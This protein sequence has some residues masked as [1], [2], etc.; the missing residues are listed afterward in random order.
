MNYNPDMEGASVKD[1]FFAWFE[2]VEPTSRR[3]LR[4][5]KTHSFNLHL[6]VGKTTPLSWAICKGIGEG[7]FALRLLVL[8]LVVNSPLH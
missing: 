8:A 2:V 3:D 6:E 4:D 7:S 5:R 1:F